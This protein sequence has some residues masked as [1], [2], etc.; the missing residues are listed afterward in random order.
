[1][2]ALVAAADGGCGGCAHEKQKAPPPGENQEE[3]EAEKAA[4]APSGAGNEAA[5]AASGVQVAPSTPLSGAAVKPLSPTIKIIVRVTRGGPDKAF[6]F[7]GKKKLGEAPVTLERPRDSGPVDL[8]VR[9]E[10]FFPIH[11]RAYTVRNDV[12]YVKMTKLED[13][14]KL[15]GAKQEVEALPPGSTPDSVAPAPGGAPPAAAPGASPGSPSPPPA[16]TPPPPQ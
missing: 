5:Q 10:G 15:F 4:T 11:T 14:M 8:V 1:L 9:G 13:R 3:A 6:V 7:W 2:G 16:P 12:L